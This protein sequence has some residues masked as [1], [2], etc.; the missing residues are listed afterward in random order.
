MS[1]LAGVAW[2][3]LF[4]LVLALPWLI[5]PYVLQVFILTITYSML[6]LA[7]AL[8]LRVGL[9]RF[10]IA[11]W[12]GVGAYTTALLMQKAHM[13]FWLTLPIGG[14]LS[15]ALGFLIFAIAVPRGMIVFLMFGMVT[16]M[17]MQQIFGSVDFFGGWGGTGVVPHPTLGPFAFVRK[18]ELYYLGL[19][20]L[21]INL[22][23]YYALYNSRIGRAWNAVGSSLKLANSV[24]INVVKYRMANVLVGNFFLA[25]AGGYFVAF[26]LVAVPDTFG[27]QNSIFVMMYAVVGGLF[28]GLAGPIIGAIIVTFIPEYLRLAKEYEPIITSVAMILIIVFLPMGVLGLVDNLRKGGKWR[29]KKEGAVGRA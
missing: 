22:L 1:K 7:F 12:W 16:A 20:L 29:G 10:D 28:H 8:S 27:F 13:S 5:N 11:A 4:A 26:S 2:A 21:G 18:P 19:F 25:V 23:A 6:G 17:A 14:L 15:M 24:G 9:P 3:A